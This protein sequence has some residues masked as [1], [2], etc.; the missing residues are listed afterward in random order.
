VENGNSNDRVINSIATIASRNRVAENRS[1]NKPAKVTATASNSASPGQVVLFDAPYLLVGDGNDPDKTYENQ[2]TS[3]WGTSGS[4]NWKTLS[5]ENIVP[6]GARAV[7]LF[8]QS[9]RNSG[10]S[11]TI[12]GLR[13]RRNG[14]DFPAVYN[15]T[16]ATTLASWEARLALPIDYDGSFEAFLDITNSGTYD[17]WVYAEGYIK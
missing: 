8:C 17:T 7:M 14:L 11:S 5:V 12:H 1:V 2:G 9:E 4:P 10:L 13:L 3:Y 16:K 15:A 6:P